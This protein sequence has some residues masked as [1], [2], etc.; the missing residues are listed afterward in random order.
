M[1]KDFMQK[2]VHFSGICNI[3]NKPYEVLAVGSDSKVWHTGEHPKE[4]PSSHAMSQVQLMT[5]G[6]FFFTASDSETTTG[7]IQIWKLPMT[8]IGEVQAHG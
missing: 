5:N 6:H 3:P 8:Y 4:T 7:S 1:D 2:G